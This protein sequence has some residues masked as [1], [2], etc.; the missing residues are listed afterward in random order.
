MLNRFSGWQSR[1]DQAL[2]QRR[3]MKLYF[4]VGSGAEIAA[5]EQGHEPD[6]DLNPKLP[7]HHGASGSITRLTASTIRRQLEISTVTCFRPRGVS[8]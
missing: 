6:A 2:L 5:A 7:E 8:L 4:F 1:I 3:Q